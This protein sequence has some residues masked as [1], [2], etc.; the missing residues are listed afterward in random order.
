MELKLL[1]LA[2]VARRL[3]WSRGTIEDRIKSGILPPPVRQGQNRCW[4]ISEVDAVAAGIAAG[5]PDDA[6]KELAAQ[7]AAVRQKHLDRAL[8]TALGG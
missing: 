5:V 8:S 7:L 1:K 6:M 2:D 4:L 3:S